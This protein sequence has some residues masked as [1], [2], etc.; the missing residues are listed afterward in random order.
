MHASPFR[1]LALGLCLGAAE[2]LGAAPAEV[3]ADIYS[4]ER[5][6]LIA[7]DLPLTEIEAARFWPVYERYQADLARLLQR[8]RR[9]IEE[10]GSYYEDMTDE[11]AKKLIIESL[12]LEEDLLRLWRHYL[13]V[14]EKVLPA[15]KLARYYQIEGKIRAAVNAEIAERLPLMK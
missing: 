14:F 1:A 5:R 10:Y 11:M 6:R 12:D 13:P 4:E 15:K 9:Y 3:N 2:V 8:R 7:E